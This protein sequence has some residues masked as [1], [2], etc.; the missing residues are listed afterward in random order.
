MQDVATIK[1]DDGDD[2][3]DA[4]GSDDETDA[5]TAAADSTPS[6]IAEAGAAGGDPTPFIDR[7]F[8]RNP[9]AQKMQCFPFVN[10]PFKGLR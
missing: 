1:E 2:D 7:L 5:E 4:V 9:N 6:E 10:N 3:A 8:R